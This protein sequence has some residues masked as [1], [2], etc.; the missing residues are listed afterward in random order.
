MEPQNLYSADHHFFHDAIL[1]W[2]AESRPFDNLSQ[3]HDYLIEVHNARATSSTDVYFLGDFICGK[4]VDETRLRKIFEKLKGRKHLVTGN[5]DTALLGNLRWSSTPSAYKTVN[6]NG[7]RIFLAHYAMYSWP[8][9]Q[10][11]AFHFYGHTHG[12]LPS[13]GRSID[14]GVDAW[15][16]APATA[17]EVIARMAAWNTD[18]ETYD[19]ER[20][21]LIT[22]A[23]ENRL[24]TEPSGAAIQGYRP[25][26]FAP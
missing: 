26:P 18:F 13:H 22:C 24:V 12:R 20:G 25:K 6:D 9:L 16:L 10:R 8:G 23:D 4:R 7:R 1:D 5:H 2:C 19:P 15:N 21:S 11:G 14:V 3:M 17:D